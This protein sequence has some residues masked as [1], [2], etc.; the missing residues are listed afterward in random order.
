MESAD[1]DTL[2]ASKG[3]RVVTPSGMVLDGSLDRIEAP[4]L[5]DNS[6][7]GDGDGVTNEVPTS[8]V[9]YFEFYLL[10]YF[11]AG[12]L[13]ET[14]TT[15]HGREVFQKIGCAS[16]HRSDLW[17]EHDRRVADVTTVSDPRGI[18][19]G[20][21]ASATPLISEIYDIS[22][23]PSL[24]RPLRNPFLVQNIFTDFKRHD[25]GPNFHERN[26]DG[27]MQTMFMTAPLW[28]VAST[29]PYGH[30]GRSINLEQVILRHGGEA[31]KSRD[32]YASLSEADSAAVLSL[33][34]SL[35][36]FPPDDTASNLDPGNRQDPHFPQLGHGSIKLTVLF[37]DPHDPE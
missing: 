31:Q 34:N 16:C 8:L 33:L 11:K 15:L 32:R 27:T 24:K 25:L 14:A 7:D 19:N 28:G 36:L 12:N 4:P 5:T 10:N 3:A 9:D 26:Y 21:F 2:A 35:V 23:F 13:L 29:G 18:F 37:N 6:Q 1:P 22:G 20:L 17:I 30:D